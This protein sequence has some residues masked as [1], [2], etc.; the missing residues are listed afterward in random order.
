MKRNGLPSKP[1]VSKLG[2]DLRKI[3]DRIAASGL[4]PLS[5]REIERE[6]AERRGAR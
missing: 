1:A 3:S 5:R 2:G 6:V 4:K